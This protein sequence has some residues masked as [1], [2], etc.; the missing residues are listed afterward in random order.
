MRNTSCLAKGDLLYFVHADT[1][2]PLTYL[3]DIILEVSNGFDL[4]RYLSSYN[5]PSVLLKINALLSRLDVFGAMGGDQT[6]F[7]TKK[8][9]ENLKGF[10]SSMTIMEEFEF[11]ARA[12]KSGRYKIIKKHVKISTRKYEINSWLRIQRANYTIVKMYK[13][14][15]SQESMVCRYKEMLNY[16]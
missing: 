8:L 11:C 7:I 15:A 5:S 12:R 10:N 6:L 2:P 14:G 9:F 13:N 4:G 3:S 1:I 16:R